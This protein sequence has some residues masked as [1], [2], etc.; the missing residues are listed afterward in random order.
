MAFKAFRNDFISLFQQNT[1]EVYENDHG[2][3]MEK[4]E[5]YYA[6]RNRYL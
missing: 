6:W 4:D 1:F 5:E 3:D 2:I